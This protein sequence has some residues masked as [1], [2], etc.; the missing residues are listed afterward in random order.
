MVTNIELREHVRRIEAFVGM[1]DERWD[2]PN[3]V[4]LLTQIMGIKTEIEAFRNEVGLYR[5]DID[6]HMAETVNSRE[7]MMLQVEVLTKDNAELRSELAVLRLAIAASGQPRGEHSKVRIPEPKTFG[8][9]RSAKE[10]ENFLW[11]MEQYFTTA[12]IAE[13]DKLNI[14]TMYLAGDAKLWWRTRNADDESANRPK[15]DTWDK[16]KKEMRD[17]FL[18]SNAS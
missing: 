13:N 3:L 10:L 8:G 6:D 1:T 14:T 5:A 17:Q 11:D 7:G 12:R 2:D 15:I 9:A 4:D 16:L 18:P